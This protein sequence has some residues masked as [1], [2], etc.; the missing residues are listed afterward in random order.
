MG[1]RDRLVTAAST[2]FMERGYHGATIADILDE[3]DLPKGSLYHHFP[4]GKADLG[5][6]AAL[7]AEKQITA[8]INTTFRASQTWRAAIELFCGRLAALFD[9]TELGSRCPVASILLD[10][11]QPLSARQEANR[12]YETWIEVTVENLELL[13]APDPRETAEKLMV[14]LQGTW[15]IARASGNSDKLR[16]LPNLVLGK[17]YGA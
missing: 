9:R 15:V 2:V 17:A 1:S 5:L 14:M 13:D 8:L 11:H 12:I 6:A 7:D 4:N 10:G 16:N 3:S